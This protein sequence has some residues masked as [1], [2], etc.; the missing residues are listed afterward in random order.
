MAID[1]LKLTSLSYVGL[2]TL[3]S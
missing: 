3:C 1:R 2:R